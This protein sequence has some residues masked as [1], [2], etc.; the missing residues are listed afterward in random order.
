MGG[1]VMDQRKIQAEV[2]DQIALN[3]GRQMVELIVAQATIAALQEHL[4]IATTK[5]PGE[6]P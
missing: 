5:E 4:K 1:I 6:K 3:L 2:N